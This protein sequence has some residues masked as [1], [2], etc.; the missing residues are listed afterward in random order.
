MDN[1]L[2]EI[3]G[4]IEDI[5]FR[6]EENGY[7]VFSLVSENDD[8]LTAFGIL[9]L[10]NSG[11][12]VKLIG[13]FKNHPSY[14]SQ[15][16]VEV[17]QR[18]LP[19]TSTAIL[20][21]LSSGAIKGIGPVIARRLVEKFNEDTLSV[22]ENQPELVCKVKGITK[23][24]A[25]SFS[26]EIKKIFGVR[27][28][29]TE[30]QKYSITAQESVRIWK[31]FGEKALSIIKDNPYILCSSDLGISFSKAD[32]VAV[33]NDMPKNNVFRVQAGFLHILEHNKRNGHT[34]LPQDK[35]LLACA[36]FL[37]TD[38]DYLSSILEDMVIDNQLIREVFE[39]RPF[40]FLPDMHNYE[41]Y[42]STRLFMSLRFPS[43][44]ISNIYEQISEIEQTQNLEYASLQKKAITEALSS[45]LLILTG[46]PGTGKTT[47]LNAIIKI[48]KQNG[49]KV[50]LAAPTGRAV[51]RMSEVTNCEA[52]TLHRLLE[53]T[54]DKSDKPIFKR[55]ERNMLDCDALIIDE[56]SMVDAHLFDSV[57][58]ALPMSCRLIL[59]GDSDQLP[60]VGAGNI[61][62]DL[63]NSNIMPVVKLTEIFRQ[64][65]Q[66]LIVTNAHSIVK[67]EMPNLTTKDNDFFFINRNTKEQVIETITQLCTTR[68]PKSYGY[69]VLNDIQVLSPARKGVLGS[70]DINKNLQN[71]INPPS[72]NKSE[73]TIN[74][75]LLRLGDKVM[76][77]KNDYDIQWTRNNGE[78]GEGVFNG[79]IGILTDINKLSKRLTVTFDD[80]TAHYDFDSATDLELA[81]ATT[82]HK[83]QGNEFNAV[84]IPM[85]QGPPQLYYR[86]L[87]YTAVTRAKK[88]LILV[89][90]QNTVFKMVENNKKTLRYSGLKFFL[91][92]MDNII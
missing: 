70:L 33:S 24:K 3:H 30:M 63:I 80:K 77:I 86:N 92:D 2:Y 44:Q 46:G 72:A 59:V 17:C 78:I 87:L 38:T 10:I 28:L 5:I 34:C 36:K 8:L 37:D 89:G 55:N 50:F 4:E 45:G 82:V 31:V 39:D 88:L 66:S 25:N 26:N 41:T 7:T 51:Q 43:N 81:Y 91:T 64:S 16:A 71:A 42:I 6:N 75:L 11:E 57:M 69:S 22:L 90:V 23:E 61:L 49:E 13:K 15:F 85:H 56:L 68:I 47:T 74:G 19:T 84:I 62:H 27:E 12:T 54:W 48:L 53:V 58:R 40:L 21:Y 20:K 65:M 29:I 83:S 52:K 76:Q 67:G 35:L 73:I 9:P 79:D 1:K 32:L 18:T 60:S 14:G